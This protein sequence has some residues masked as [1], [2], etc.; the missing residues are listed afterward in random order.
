MELLI[1]LAVLY[2]LQ[3]LVWLPEGSALFVRP[4]G[5]WRVTSGPGWRVL[6]P[7]PSGPAWLA[8]R[9]P[10]IERAGRLYGRAAPTWLASRAFSDRG[11]AVPRA[12]LAGAEARGSVV[13]VQGRAFAR[14]VAP[15]EAEPLARFLRDLG[16]SPPAQAEALV[17][18]RLAESLSLSRYS[19][20]R[21]R[22]GRAT[23]GLRWSSDVYFAGLYVALPGAALAWAS[24]PALLWALPALAALHL[25]TLAV[26]ARTFRRLY[27]EGRGE[28]VE[29]VLAAALYP[30]QL[31]RAWSELR[32]RAMAGFHPAVVAV[33]TLPEAA[34]RAFL[35]GEI[36][37]A[38][39][40]RG[41]GA[42]CEAGLAELECR[43]L[44][45]LVAEIG[46]SRETLLAAPV[47]QHPRAKGYC[48]AC[49]VEYVRASGACNDCDV[50]LAP[51]AT[52][53]WR[54]S[55]GTSR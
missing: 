26:Y 30:P 54:A 51:Y 27:P 25:A 18:E 39:R 34:G 16:A 10:L 2:G 9:L 43:A 28:R 45:D 6:H 3:C 23:P 52:S 1:A 50:A 36:L 19:E 7:W 13:R 55:R 22:F 47:R 12:A 37:R 14:A 33:A 20:A 29:A 24:E 15:A 5:A 48:P 40:E 8:A 35:R 17:E 11:R 44:W 38:S 31:L 49:H 4:L 42:L 46:E 32:T 21:E 53:S 41:P